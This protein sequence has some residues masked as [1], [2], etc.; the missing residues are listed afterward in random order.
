LYGVLLIRGIG[1]FTSLEGMGYERLVLLAM[2]RSVQFR[3]DGVMVLYMTSLFF[4]GHW[5][6]MALEQACYRINRRTGQE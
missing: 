5:T 1:V 3:S 4:L 2:G 6:C